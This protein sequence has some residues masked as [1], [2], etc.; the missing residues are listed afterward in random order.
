MITLPMPGS[1]RQWGCKIFLFIHVLL[2]VNT[3]LLSIFCGI[4][5]FHFF[6]QFGKSV[7]YKINSVT[8]PVPSPLTNLDCEAGSQ[9]CPD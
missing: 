4:E 2:Y 8:N 3:D 1:I 9:S 6:Q 5:I 7:S